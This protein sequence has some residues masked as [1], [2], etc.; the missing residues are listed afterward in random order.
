LIG[1]TPAEAAHHVAADPLLVFRLVFDASSRK[2]WARLLLPVAGLSVA[3]WT[4]WIFILLPT[5]EMFL[6][7]F[8]PMKEVVL[9][10]P[11]FLCPVYFLSAVIVLSHAGRMRRWV[12]PWLAT[13][14]LIFGALFHYFLDPHPPITGTLNW[15]YNNAGPFGRHFDWDCYHVNDHDRAT[16]SFLDRFVPPGTPLATDHRFSHD[17]SNRFVL[18]EFP[19]IED[20]DLVFLDVLTPRPIAV[21]QVLTNLKTDILTFL[22]SGT[23]GVRNYDDGDALLE[24]GAS[25]A[26]NLA[27]AEDLVG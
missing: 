25:T 24:R 1:H 13:Y 6:S 22:E 11:W 15:Y 10:Y 5:M 23:F 16:R 12:S 20:V 17:L 26:A 9:H 7:Q 18:R 2:N 27:L 19:R 21:R 8:R 3:H 14:L 4:G